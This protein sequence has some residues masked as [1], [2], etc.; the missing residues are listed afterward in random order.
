MRPPHTAVAV[1]AGALLVAGLSGCGWLPVAHRSPGSRVSLPPARPEV[2][3]VIL[4]S[5]SAV[6]QA[7]FRSFVLSTAQSGERLVVLSAATGNAIDSF[8]APAASSMRGPAFPAPLSP[9]AT[10]F[11]H[12]RYERSLRSADGLLKQDRAVLRRRQQRTLTAWADG[13][14]A[15]TL[16]ALSHTHPSHPGTLASAFTE[17]V[18][19]LAVLPQV[20]SPGEPSRIVAVIGVGA[21]APPR[22]FACL[23]GTAV[24]VTD[25]AEGDED[26]SW[27]ADFL[28]ACASQVYVVNQADDADL[29]GIARLALTAP[30]QISFPLTSL[31]YGPAQ[32]SVPADAHA[33]LRQL[34]R[35]LTVSYPDADATIYGYT[36]N[37]AV[38]G[39][40]LELSLKRARAVLSWLVAH[41]V[42]ASRLQAIGYGQADPEAPNRPGGQPLNRRVMVIIS[43]A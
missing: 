32:F 2:A 22:L 10:A 24:V 3:A 31:N 43:P 28:R 11:Q 33:R 34:L 19:N 9:D 39:G 13:S 42:P 18:A 23:S 30:R 37:I 16:S 8:S 6:A 14:V 36:D 20:R 5:A 41:G 26:A 40:N 38:P 27:Q 35:L 7:D 1:A 21:M 17:A 12:A 25:I 15:Q 4:A 29:G